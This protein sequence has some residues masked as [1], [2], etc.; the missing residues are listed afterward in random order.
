MLVEEFDL[1]EIELYSDFSSVEFY[2]FES[3]KELTGW[4]NN[5]VISSFQN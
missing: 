1:I 2:S 5:Q 3:E 4:L